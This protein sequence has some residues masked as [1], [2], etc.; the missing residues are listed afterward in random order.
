MRESSTRAAEVLG[1]SSGFHKVVRLATN[2]LPAIKPPTACGVNA[3]H[4]C[5]RSPAACPN[6]GVQCPKIPPAASLAREQGTFHLDVNGGV[7]V[8]G[9]DVESPAHKRVVVRAD[10]TLNHDQALRLI[11]NDAADR[12]AIL[13]VWSDHDAFASEADDT[14]LYYTAGHF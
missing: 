1:N 10:A 12:T 5:R 14:Y 8:G 2:L 11:V 4:R 9:F 3:R 6:F 7:A 13:Y